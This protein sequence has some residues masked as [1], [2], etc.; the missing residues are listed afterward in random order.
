MTRKYTVKYLVR[1]GAGREATM[2]ATYDCKMVHKEN[3]T[4]MCMYGKR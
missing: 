3:N 1:E 2:S 4:Y